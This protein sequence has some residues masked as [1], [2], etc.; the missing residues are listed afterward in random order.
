[1]KFSFAILLKLQYFYNICDFY[2]LMY[3]FK[4][5]GRLLAR[6]LLAK[7]SLDSTKSQ[8]RRQHVCYISNIIEITKKKHKQIKVAIKILEKEKIL[9]E[10][11]KTRISREIQIL[12]RIRHPNIIQLFEIIETPRKLFLIMEYAPNSEL[13]DYIVQRTRQII[14]FLKEGNN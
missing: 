1:M 4:K 5:K 13:F 8:M 10:G 6:V 3:I 14:N 2:F 11:D 9:D 12:R 7:S